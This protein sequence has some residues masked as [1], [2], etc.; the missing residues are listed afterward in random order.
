[1]RRTTT[2]TAVL[3]AVVAV[4]LV[5]V[6]SSA[7]APYRGANTAAV[8]DD[9]DGD[10]YRDLAVGAP[11]AA[12]GSL[13]EA[14]AVVVMYGSASSVSTTRRTVITQ[15]S[16]GVPGAAEERDM[17]GAAV[18]SADLDRDGYADLLVGTPREDVGSRESRGSVTVLWGGPGGLSGGATITPPADF[19]EGS[20]YCGFGMA[21]ATGD[22]DG[23]GAPE[24]SVGSRC[25]GS[26]YTGPFD[27]TGRA[28]ASKRHQNIGMG[29]GVVMGDVNG[30][31]LA[32]RFWLPGPASGD[33]GGKVSFEYLDPSTGLPAG[34]P[35]ADGH[36]GLVGDVNGDGYGDLV[37]GV[38]RDDRRGAPGA[39]HPGGEIQVLY[40]GAQGIS[41]DQHPRVFHQ[42]TP[43]VPGVGEYDD[44]F[45]QS[46]SLGDVDGNGYTDVLVGAP[47]EAIGSRERAGTTV[48]L[49]GSPA[50]L[51]TAGAAAYH[52][53]TASV[54]GVAEAED[55]FGHAVHLADLDGDGRAEVV[56]GT[57]GENA[58]GCLWHARGT[59]SGPAVGGSV[60]LCGKNAGLT[61]K[62][63]EGLFG[64]ALGS[65]R[66]AL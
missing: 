36:T 48:L 55:L 59:A 29:R 11:G 30:D 44:E 33:L 1:M 19:G 38:P 45:G 39:A 8:Q 66:A 26:G 15:A 12:F 21:L 3:A 64:A 18:A 65:A 10:G 51:T 5:P 40:G 63:P 23:D 31:G 16:P 24:V 4:A 53:D 37:T 50:G 61:L 47:G 20:L 58:D 57:P 7:A 60:N 9:F 35:H 42:D 22:M 14:G 2:A 56:A 32:E 27:R 13:E 28:A 49:R 52:Q 46:L 34:L 17:F 41:A 54:P 6:Q 62:G 25:E 43:G